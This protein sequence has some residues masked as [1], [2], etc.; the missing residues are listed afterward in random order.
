[1]CADEASTPPLLRAVPLPENRSV[2]VLGWTDG[3]KARCRTD[4]VS[5]DGVNAYCVGSMLLMKVFKPSDVMYAIL[6]VLTCPALLDSSIVR[7]NV[8]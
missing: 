4:G 6:A 3:R 1:M 8:K 5:T 7:K 2:L